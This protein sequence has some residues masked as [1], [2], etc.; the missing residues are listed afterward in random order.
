MVYQVDL[1]DSLRVDGWRFSQDDRIEQAERG[2]I[3]ADAQAERDDRDEGE[4][5]PRAETAEGILQVANESAHWGLRH[6]EGG[7][8]RAS[9]TPLR[10]GSETV[11]RADG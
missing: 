2:G 7:A 5:D 8:A 10:N 4:T 6:R 3:D 9:T 11:S 1:G